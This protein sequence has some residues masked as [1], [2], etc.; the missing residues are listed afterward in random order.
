ME[1]PLKCSDVELVRLC[2]RGDAFAWDEFVARFNRRIITYVVRERRVR[3]YVHHSAEGDAVSDLCQEVYVRLLLNDRRALREFRGDSDFAVLT[4]LARV[5][6]AVVGDA[7]R[8]DRSKK[9]SAHVL[10][11]DAAGE[12]GSPS[13]AE[14]LKADPRLDP[15][16]LMDERL[17][18]DRLREL[19]V[20]DGGPNAGRDIMLYQLHVLEG[21]SARELAE[22]SPSKLSVAAVETILRRTR[23]RLK[24]SVG[25]SSNLSV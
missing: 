19:F 14:T 11:I 22:R 16:R 24:T 20:T 1:G 23:E 12:D 15:D 8:R 5:A 17:L 9:R 4:Y 10:P 6:R 7:E 21:L 3:G 18:P 25:G 13:L 2:G